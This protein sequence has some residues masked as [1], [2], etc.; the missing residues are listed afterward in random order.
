MLFWLL[1]GRWRNGRAGKR[2]TIE[3]QGPRWRRL[4]LLGGCCKGK[5]AHCCSCG[6]GCCSGGLPTAAATRHGGQKGCLLGMERHNLGEQCG[7]GSGA[8]GH[9]NREGLQLTLNGEE[10]LC[11]C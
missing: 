10:L 8:G 11:G 3:R 5:P 7:M 9:G 2:L 4:L 1:R 6:W